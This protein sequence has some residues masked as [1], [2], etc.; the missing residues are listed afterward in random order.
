MPYYPEEDG[1]K[2]HYSNNSYYR[3]VV[4]DY[5]GLNFNE[6]DDIGI[7]DYWG[8]LHDAVVWNC[9]K[10]EAGREYLNNAYCYSQTEPDRVS[11]REKFGGNNGK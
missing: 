2:A 5:T 10:S 4:S 1:G 8:Y 7:L 9:Q 6:L 3:K 11:L